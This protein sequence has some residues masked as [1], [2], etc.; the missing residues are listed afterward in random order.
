MYLIP[1]FLISTQ[2]IFLKSPPTTKF[3]IR[4]WYPVCGYF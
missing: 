3:C 1:N 4:H 2:Q